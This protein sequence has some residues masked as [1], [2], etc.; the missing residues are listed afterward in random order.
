MYIQRNKRVLS[1]FCVRDALQMVLQFNPLRITGF[2]AV[3][4]STLVVE[5]YY[6]YYCYISMQ[7]LLFY[8]YFGFFKCAPHINLKY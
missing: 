5:C 4:N 1:Q 6:Y 8:V 7:K 2:V 3:Q